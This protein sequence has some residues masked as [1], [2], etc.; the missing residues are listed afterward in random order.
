[1][2]RLPCVPAGNGLRPETSTD[3]DAVKAAAIVDLQESKGASTGLTASLHPAAHTQLF[4]DLQSRQGVGRRK[5]GWKAMFDLTLH[6][7]APAFAQPSARPWQLCISY[8]LT[9]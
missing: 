9:V 8:W 2:G 6:A 1:M 4:P 7:L 5:S 3:L